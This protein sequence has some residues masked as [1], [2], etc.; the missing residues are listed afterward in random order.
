MVRIASRDRPGNHGSGL[1]FCGRLGKGTKQM[2]YVAQEKNDRQADLAAGQLAKWRVGLS[3]LASWPED[4]LRLVDVA[5]LNLGAAFALSGAEDLN[6]PACLATLGAWARL[7]D[8]KIHLA[9]EAVLVG[10]ADPADYPRQDRRLPIEHRPPG[11][12]EPDLRA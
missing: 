2:L 4:R 6:M 11:R 7:V 10:S 1:G 8:E 5:E 3:R 9:K 12:Q